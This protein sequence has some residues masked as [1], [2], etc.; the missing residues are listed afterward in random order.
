MKDVKTL[1]IIGF[2]VMGAAIGMNA[3]ASGYQV[4][5]KEINDDLVKKMYE[6]NVVNTLSKRV[7]KGKI[8]Q[9]VMDGITGNIK[10]TTS[11]DDLAACDLIIEAAIENMELKMKIFKELSDSCPEDAILVSNTSTFM[12]EKLMENVANP[13]RT[14][15]FH[16][17]FPANVNK[18]VEVI[19]QKE[20]TQETYEALM[21][22][23]K[24]NQK[25]PITVKDFPGFAINPV[26][27]SAY[28]TLDN[29]YGETYNAA[30][31]EDISKEALGIKYGVLW[32]QNMGG[33]GTAYHA[34]KSMVDYLGDSDVGFPPVSDELKVKFEKNELFDLEDG[35]ILQDKE[36]RAEVK[37]TL[38]GAIFAI[39][40]HL[41]EN[42]VATAKDLDLGI[43][44]ALAWPKGPLTLMNEMGMEETA[45]LVK[46]SVDKGYYKMPK[47][48][49]S[50][51]LSPWSL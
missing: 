2:G 48:I 19:R 27:I 51:D 16:Y 34:A 30:T 23:A 13:G 39:S 12:I 31:L 20:T 8:T 29:L 43:C 22:F 36:A 40:M 38:L 28:L 4:V 9:D 44:T 35:P 14:A 33:L 5:F 26:F 1:G 15:G 45:R 50:G 24:N 11:Y 17:F 3:A 41:I 49:A 37:D 46:K 47:K 32:V 6:K 21:T 18:L 25:V 7:E 10:G 42:E